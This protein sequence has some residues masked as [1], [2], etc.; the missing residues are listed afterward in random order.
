MRNKLTP[1]QVH[2]VAEY[3]IDLN[4]TQA[5]IRAGYSE[6]TAEFTLFLEMC[7]P[8]RVPV[9]MSCDICHLLNG[10]YPPFDLEGIGTVP[11]LPSAFALRCVGTDETIQRLPI[12]NSLIPTLVHDQRVDI[13]LIE[14]QRVH[15]AAV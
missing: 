4:A 10:R 13:W 14:S 6:R 12:E 3:L 2:F 9:V 11:W 1:K 8:K 15:I 5:A 7:R